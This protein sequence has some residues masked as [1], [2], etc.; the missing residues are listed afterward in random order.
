[1][2]KHHIIVTLHA[3]YL[4]FGKSLN[5]FSQC[6]KTVSQSLYCRFLGGGFLTKYVLKLLL[7]GFA[8]DT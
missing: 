6:S 8:L 4:D 1:M 3:Y 5:K 2:N 7:E